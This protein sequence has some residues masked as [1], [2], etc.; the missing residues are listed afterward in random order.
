MESQLGNGTDGVM[1]TPMIGAFSRGEGQ[2]YDQENFGQR[3]IMSR[4]GLSAITPKSSCF[5]QTFSKDAGKPWE[6]N[7]I[8]TF[9]R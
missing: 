9:T 3:V 1:T 8:M 5:E 6:T 2:F 4:N 7:W